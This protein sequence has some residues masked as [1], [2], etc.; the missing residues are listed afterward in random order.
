MIGG[1]ILF[2][3]HPAAGAMVRKLG[4]SIGSADC[5]DIAEVFRMSLQYWTND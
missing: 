1:S 3:I 2:A 4:P 5:L